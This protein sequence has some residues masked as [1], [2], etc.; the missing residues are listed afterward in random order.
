MDWKDYFDQAKGTGF[1]ATANRKGEANIAI[2]SKPN[3][4][5]DG[6]LAFA[7]TDRLTHANLSEN[8]SAV[9][10]FLKSGYKG[11]RI[12]LEKVREDTGSP[13][14]EQIRDRTEDVDGPEI[15]GQIRF[16]VYFRVL[17]YLPL[18]GG[19]KPGQKEFADAI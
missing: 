8:P 5:R 13:V 2:F 11:V 18:V 10:A 15:S 7:M 12:Y 17:Q 19:S 9:Y 6:T 1:L 16:L 4:M 3:V 14:L